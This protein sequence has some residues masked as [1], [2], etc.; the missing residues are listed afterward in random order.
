MYN[1]TIEIA[2]S[3][4]IPNIIKFE[5]EAR[6]TE[7]N[8]L[9]WDIDEIAYSENLRSLNIDTLENSKIIIAKENEKIIGRCDIAIIL[10][11]VD[12]KK[13]GYID[14]IYT[15]KNYRSK[16]IGKN[17]LKGAEDYFKSKNVNNYFL[18]TA[19]NKDAQAFYHKQID[20]Q[21]SQR[22]IATKKLK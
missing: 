18:E 17:L 2:T 9:C 14:W 12:C 3:E 21:F 1:I 10:S 15:L 13:T 16:G 22:E 7:P 11:L 8:V 5:K 20:L 19:T 4:D 6:L